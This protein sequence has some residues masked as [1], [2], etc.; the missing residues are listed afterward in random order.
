MQLANK[1]AWIDYVWGTPIQNFT[2]VA[3]AGA[4]TKMESGC[5]FFVV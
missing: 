5:L 1:N 2:V 3:P 4:P